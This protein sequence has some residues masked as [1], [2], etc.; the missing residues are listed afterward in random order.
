MKLFISEVPYLSVIQF[1]FSVFAFL[2]LNHSSY[3]P[4]RTVKPIFL[5][6]AIMSNPDKFFSA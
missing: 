3:Q 5:S 2:L 1:A 6:R 4:F